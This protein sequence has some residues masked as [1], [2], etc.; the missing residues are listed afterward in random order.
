MIEREMVIPENTNLIINDTPLDTGLV[1]R[2]MRRFVTSPTSFVV[3]DRQELTN[4]L[5]ENIKRNLQD[6]RNSLGIIFPGQ[7]A[8]QVKEV[9]PTGFV[10]SIKSTGII[11]NT[12]TSRIYK[13]NLPASLNADI[14]KDLI[15]RINTKEITN[16]WIVDDVIATGQTIQGMRSDVISQLVEMQPEDK[17]YNPGIRF[18]FP[19]IKI[20]D[21][22]FSAFT[23]LKQK[24]AKTENFDVFASIVYF[25]K[26]SKVSLTSLSTFLGDSDKSND[27]KRSYSVKYFQDACEFYRFIDRLK[28][29]L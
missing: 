4:S 13:D 16:V 28:K 3:F 10:E 2:A 9:L 20:P 11:Y 29:Q 21:T 1:S 8:Q 18:S 5:V 15:E 17:N 22:S 7:G 27:V 23:W 26:S 14:P 24:S 12:Q 19:Q 6:R 25:R